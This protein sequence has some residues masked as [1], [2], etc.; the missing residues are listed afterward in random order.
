MRRIVFPMMVLALVAAPAALDAQTQ[1]EA[2]GARAHGWTQGAAGARAGQAMNP[3][4]RVLAQRAELGLTSDQVYQLEAIQA[5]VEA[6]AGPLLAQLEA[7]RG[8]FAPGRI[9]AGAAPRGELARERAA[10]MTPEQ[11]ARMRE[12]MQQRARGDAA[13]RIADPEARAR[14]EALRPVMQQLHATHTQ[15]RQDVQAVLSAEQRTQLR[16]LQQ[17]RVGEA[18]ARVRGEPGAARRG[19]GP[20]R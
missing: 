5:R 3:A 12:R 16:A 11:R 14:M 10:A 13:A 20:R 2:R 18:R 9:G 6:Q 1:R 8:E 4:A 17:A 7:A 15:A 19:P